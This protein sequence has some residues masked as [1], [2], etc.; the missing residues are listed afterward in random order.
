MEFYKETIEQLLVDIKELD[1]IK[2]LKKKIDQIMDMLANMKTHEDHEPK[3]RPTVHY[4]GGF[5]EL[6]VYN[7]FL[8]NNKIQ[9]DTINGRI[10]ELKLLIDG[11]LLEL[12][13]RDFGKDLKNLEDF[14]LSKFEELR[15][16]CNKKFADKNDTAKNLKYFD[17]QI[18]HILEVYLKKVDKGDNWLLAKKPIDGFSCASCEA[19]IGELHD[20]N[21]YIPWN[22]YPMRDPNEKLYR[23]GNGFSRMLQ[24]LNL[25]N[26]YNGGNK[27]KDEKFQTSSN[28]FHNK[29]KDNLLRESHNT[30]TDDVVPNKKENVFSKT[31]NSFHPKVDHLNEHFEMDEKNEDPH[32]PK[33]TKIYK[34]MKKNE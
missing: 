22:K 26:A 20:N 10:D 27:T 15:I 1:Q 12:K 11:I 4:E 8:R 21:Q 29:E 31:K 25:D 3:Q 16:A 14:L 5:V 6:T 19:Y 17:A 18:K 32:A 13:K 2:L 30:N 34:K 33:I 23:V 7:E 24:M 28:F 9:I